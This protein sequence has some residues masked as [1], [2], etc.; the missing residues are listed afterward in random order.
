MIENKLWYAV[1]LNEDDF[2][3]GTG[4]YDFDEA[5]EYAIKYGFCRVV[6]VE[7]GPDPIAVDE[8]YIE[9]E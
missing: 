4:F 7:L 9:A 3:W 2:D 6:T 8:Y 5:V 1:Q